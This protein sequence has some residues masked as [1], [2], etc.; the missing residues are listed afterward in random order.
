MG[1]YL[2]KC[3]HQGHMGTEKSKARARVCVYWPNMYSEIENTV[4]QCVV[5]N[6]YTST[7]H[8]EPLLPHPVPQYRWEK[9]GVDYFTL[10][11]KDLLLIVD[12][13]SKHTEVVW[14]N[15]KTAWAT[16]AKLKMIFARHGIP[17]VVIADNMPFNSRELK[18]F[19]MYIMEFSDSYL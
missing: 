10:G 19:A 12:Y 15:S 6:R 1:S 11:G 5:C 14:M 4:K 2:L 3:I 7:N 9:V 18:T 8:K 17:R 16:I 13:Y